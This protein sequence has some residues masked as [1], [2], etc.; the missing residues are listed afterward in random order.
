V[1]ETLDP[2][3]PW[4]FF[5]EDEAT[6]EGPAAPVNTIFLTNRKCPWN[7][8]MCD[9]WE[10]TLP[11]T[12]PLGAIPA[13][14]DYALARISRARTVKLYNSGSFFD[15]RAIPVADYEAIASRIQHYDRVIVESHPAL[16][17]P[18]CFRFQSLIPGQLE[19]A[20]GLETVNPQ[21][22]PL[23]EKR[24]TLADFKQAA[25]ALRARNIDL[26]VFII[27]KPPFETDDAQALHWACRSLDFAFDCGATAA[28]VIPARG[29]PDPPSV[30]LLEAAQQYGLSLKRGRVFSDL[31]DL[32]DCDRLRHMNLTQTWPALCTI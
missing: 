11:E 21:V 20:M 3:R 18:N 15:P 6:L 8:V 4:L 14:I 27:L 12:V 7:C 23:L 32:K 1:S 22:L 17:G 30:E 10:N 19:V 31:W 2:Y 9:L 16:V 13:Q 28:T 29:V 24:M 5:T 26:R 25:E